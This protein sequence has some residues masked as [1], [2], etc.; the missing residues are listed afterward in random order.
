MKR[1]QL[2]ACL[3]V[4]AVMGA[5]IPGAMAQD[6]SFQGKTIEILVPADP[7]G[8]SDVFARMWAPY[9]SKYLPG[10]PS[11]VIQNMPGGGQT[12]G[13][14]YF[15]NRG[16]SDGSMLYVTSG[17]TH[18]SY[19]LNDSRVNYDLKDWIP[20]SI[21]PN[22][23]VV[24]VSSDLGLESWEDAAEL[25]DVSLV[26][27]SQGPTSL[28]L[29]HALSFE[30]LGLDVR[31]VFGFTGRGAGR[32]AF[33]RG[34]TNIDVQTTPAYL[35][36]VMPLVEEGSVTP[37][38]SLGALDEEGNI[39]RDPTF[40]EL[41]S[42]VEFYE[43]LHGEAPS[44]TQFDAWRAFFTAGFAAQKHNVLNKGTPPEIVEAYR[45]AAIQIVE[46]PD[47]QRA[48]AAELGAYQQFVGNAVEPISKMTTDL[49]PETQQW[50]RDWLT[51]R[52]N[53]PL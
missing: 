27:A 45:Q 42:F 49:A 20:A 40:P 18:F 15:Y 11:V 43:H 32:I 51:E 13:A 1:F 17:S 33:E 23:T 24:Y 14:N 52:F 8:G 36:N 5:V 37:L 53:A 50:V 12:I 16:P 48:A 39:Q 9:W 4:A 19:L 2:A 47:F 10:N 25:A 41:P 46:D 35:T 21:S 34:E 3:S 28:D 7:G 31:H 30:M 6:V 22:G 29:V 26:F 38:Y 44:G